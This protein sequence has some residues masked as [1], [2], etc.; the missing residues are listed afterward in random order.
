MIFRIDTLLKE[1]EGRT[2]TTEERQ[3]L[4]AFVAARMQF[5]RRGVMPMIDLLQKENSRKPMFCARKC[6]NPPI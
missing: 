4:D 5:G 1:Y 2:L 3:L 6:W